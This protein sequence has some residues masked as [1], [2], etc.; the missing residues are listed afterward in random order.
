MKYF[1]YL[2]SGLFLNSI[3]A[4]PGVAQQITVDGTTSTT[5]TP[6]PTGVQ[7]NQGNRGG[8]NLFH[9]FGKFSIPTG[10]EAHF[11]N[12]SDVVNIF[13]RVTGGDISNINGLLRANGT[14]NLFLINPAGI[15]FGEGA[16]LQLGGS[17]Y[18]STADSIVFPD[19]EFSATDKMSPVT[20]TI[21]APIGLNFRDEPQ[22]ITNQANSGLVETVID[23]GLETEYTAITEITGLEV[24]EGKTLGLIGGNIF[25]EGSGLTA[26]GGNVELGGL[27]ESGIIGIN[28]DGSLS[29]P[30]GVARS[31]VSL[32][33]NAIVNVESGGGG[34][35]NVNARNLTLDGKGRLIA[36]IKENMGSLDAIGGDIV[37]NATNQLK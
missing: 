30:E 15:L 9:S 27:S 24:V 5:V 37:I 8:G 2:F 33:D 11:N 4:F 3:L 12:A 21:N 10:T 14:A 18:G 17:F 20:I 29:F 16:R 31:D 25:L 22:P 34:F 35:I 1:N 32:T 23:P 26:P 36:G 7:I 28:N 19:G 6:T 13:S